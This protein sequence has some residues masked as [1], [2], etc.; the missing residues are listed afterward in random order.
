[1][2]IKLISGSRDFV[3]E[4]R[5]DIRAANSR[6]YVQAMTFEGDSAGKSIADML[7][8]SAANDRRML[9]DAY[10]RYIMSDKVIAGPF[11]RLSTAQKRELDDTISMFA[12]LESHGIGV[13]VTNPVGLLWQFFP[14]R[15]HKKLIVTDDVSY[16]GGIN[17]SDHN[18]E[19]H[20]MMVRI[21]NKEIADFLS[22]DFE[23]SWQGQPQDACL[24][25]DEFFLL[26]LSG[27]TNPRTWL[28]FR[29]QIEKATEK[30]EVVSPYITYPFLAWLKDASK[31]GVEIVIYLPAQ[32]NKG[33]VGDYAENYALRHG[34][35][36]KKTQ[37]MSHT[38]GMCIDEKWLVFGSSN[39]D[40]V[41]YYTQ[42]EYLAVLESRGAV[43][44]FLNEILSP[45][46]AVER[47]RKSSS[48]FFSRLMA[49]I[50]LRLAGIGI[51]LLKLIPRRTWVQD[52]SSVF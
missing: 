47:S 49:T 1:M 25:L 6:C 15:N 29:S 17:F 39:F 32:N 52:R 41:S 16:I 31:R 45:L 24:E 7:K 21:E 38:K 20:D 40:F 22:K 26:S 43:K 23:R 11:A 4:A 5:R 42:A 8:D 37:G 9:V 30:I 18:F 19:W 10:S 34:F 36:V 3:S 12:E 35:T 50:M 27:Q 44:T 28:K 48:S 13:R 33:L 2:K 14:S 51:C 46:E